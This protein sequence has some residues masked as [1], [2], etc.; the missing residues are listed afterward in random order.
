RSHCDRFAVQ[1][2]KKPRSPAR[3]RRALQVVSLSNAN[4]PANVVKT[5]YL[6]AQALTAASSLI[7]VLVVTAG[8]ILLVAG[9]LSWISTNNRLTQRLNRYEA[10]VAAAGAATEKVVSRMARDFQTYDNS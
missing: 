8:G 1:P 7:L 9:V 6:K 2:T 10:S 4:C 5:N 3:S